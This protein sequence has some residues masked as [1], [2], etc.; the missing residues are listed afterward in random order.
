MLTWTITANG[1]KSAQ[2]RSCAFAGGEVHR[3]DNVGEADAKV[4]AIVSP[5][6]LG[7]DCFQEL[8]AVVDAAPGGRPDPAAMAEVMRRH[9]LTTVAG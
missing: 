1:G 8:A 5:G 2:E 3:F 7:P 9:G 4:L 6:L